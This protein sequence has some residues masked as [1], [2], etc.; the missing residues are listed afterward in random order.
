LN[1]SASPVFSAGYQRFG[2]AP[3]VAEKAT[4][5][6]SEAIARQQKSYSF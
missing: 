4:A 6:R 3:R 2:S 1:L 5:S